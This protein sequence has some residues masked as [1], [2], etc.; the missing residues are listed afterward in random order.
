[1][2]GCLDHECGAHKCNWCS[3]SRP[4]RAPPCPSPRV[5]AARRPIEAGGLGLLAS[6]TSLQNRSNN[7]LL[8][9]SL[10]SVVFCYSDWDGLIQ[11]WGALPQREPPASAWGLSR[12]AQDL[13]LLLQDEPGQRH[14]SRAQGSWTKQLA[15]SLSLS[16]LHP[17]HP[18]TLLSGPFEPHSLVFQAQ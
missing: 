10:W 14:C 16:S 11:A 9:L 6:R 12:V 1:M 8:S 17:A 15:S 4:Q 18:Q 3:R 13:R 2:G 7:C 5:A